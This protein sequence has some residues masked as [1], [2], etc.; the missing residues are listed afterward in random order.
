MALPSTIQSHFGSGAGNQQP[1]F[2]LLCY[3]IESPGCYQTKW[4][5][6]TLLRVPFRSIAC[7]TPCYKKFIVIRLIL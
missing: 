7:H 4:L 3:C 1:F 2:V 5:L 6:K